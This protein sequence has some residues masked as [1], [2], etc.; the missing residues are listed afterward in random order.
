V[1]SCYHGITNDPAQQHH[2]Y[3]RTEEFR[4]QMSWLTKSGYK[5]V[6]C[7]QLLAAQPE[8]RERMVGVTFDD[9]L[10][11]N[12]SLGL[13]V[14]RELGVGCTVFVTTDFVGHDVRFPWEYCQDDLPMSWEQV[15]EMANAG[16]DIQS[17]GCS[18]AS[19]PELENEAL[20]HDLVES[21][22]VIDSELGVQPAVLAYPFGHY[23]ER[24]ESVVRQAGYKAAYAINTPV[25]Q[26]DD[27]YALSRITVRY[28]TTLFG[29]RLRVWGIHPFIK[30]RSWFRL[31]R[32]VLQRSRRAYF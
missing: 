9:G 22:R 2:N 8:D 32:P 18:H 12:H 27:P 5:P 20:L 19:F 11:S 23:D 24:V 29:F 13:P 21:K 1:E 17:H 30:S 16:V 28:Q 6:S 7:S 4:R 15:R 25:E 31:I 14:I 3:V 10:S 26:E